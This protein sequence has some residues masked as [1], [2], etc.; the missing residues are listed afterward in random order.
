MAPIRW[1]ALLVAVSVAFGAT[2]TLSSRAEARTAQEINAGAD[3]AL[4][5]FTQQVKG[6]SRLL[7]RAQGVLVFPGVIKA[8]AGV[9]A[10]FG[11]GA[12]RV[13]GR[14]V[15]YYSFSSASVGLQFGIQKK[16][17][18]IIFLSADALRRFRAKGPNE[19]WQVGVDGSV[20]LVD[21]GAGASIDSEKVNQP[22]VGFVVGQK[23]LMFNLTLEGSKITKLNK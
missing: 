16:D 6:G 14:S 19:G 3:A 23:G 4:T 15:A 11:E 5:R 7:A 22:I 1:R 18:I 20:V 2:A 21:V 9:G 8:G 17:I 13:R 12:L 10:E